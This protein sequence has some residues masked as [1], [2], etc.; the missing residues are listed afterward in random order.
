MRKDA[1]L[2]CLVLAI[3]LTWLGVVPGRS[4]AD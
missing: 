3:A 1:L 4:G 2:E